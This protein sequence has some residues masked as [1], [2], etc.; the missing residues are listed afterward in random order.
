MAFSHMFPTSRRKPGSTW[1]EVCAAQGA[2]WGQ[3]RPCLMLQV[4]RR[5]GAMLHRNYRLLSK[6]SEVVSANL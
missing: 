2:G 3:A 5:F 6:G 4:R 1:A